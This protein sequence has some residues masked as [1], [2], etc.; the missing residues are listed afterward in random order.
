MGSNGGR[1][2]LKPK[3]K[4][5]LFSLGDS[6]GGPI[7]FC[8][9]ITA[10]NSTQAVKNLRKAVD[11][12]NG[13]LDVAKATGLRGEDKNLEYFQVYIN[14]DKISEKNIVEVN[15]AEEVA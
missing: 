1:I 9:R 7:G 11:A 10:K 4:S 12:F 5:F 2:Q 15:P 3:D 13:E 8:V 14:A 6:D